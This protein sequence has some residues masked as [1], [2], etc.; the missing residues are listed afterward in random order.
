MGTCGGRKMLSFSQGR[1]RLLTRSHRGGLCRTGRPP[2]SLGGQWV[3]STPREYCS[4]SSGNAGPGQLS[5]GGM[6]GTLEAHCGCGEVRGTT[7]EGRFLPAGSLRTQ[8]WA[9]GSHRV[10]NTNSL[11]KL[12]G[13]AVGIREAVPTKGH[14]QI[15]LKIDL[16]V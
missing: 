16:G 1:V 5:Q 3:S 7:S 11:S 15:A 14:R 6:E 12:Q 2:L 13:Q 8:P 4:R 10:Q 9:T